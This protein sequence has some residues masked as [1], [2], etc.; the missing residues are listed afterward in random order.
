MAAKHQT[1]A[2]LR[3]E[4]LSFYLLEVHQ[5][6]PLAEHIRRGIQPEPDDDL[7]GVMY[8]WMLEQASQ[9]VTSTTRSRISAS[10]AFTRGTTSSIGPPNLITVLVVR[11][12]LTMDGCAAIVQSRRFEVRG[13][14]RRR[15]VARG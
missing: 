15:S 8:Q 1:S 5:G 2:D 11:L 13:D 3:P 9:A 7:A 4:H 10:Q 14:N 12:T 6:T